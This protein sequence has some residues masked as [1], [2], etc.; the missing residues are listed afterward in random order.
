MAKSSKDELELSLGFDATT[1]RINFS[2]KLSDITKK[3]TGLVRYVERKILWPSRVRNN[4]VRDAKNGEPPSDASAPTGFE[5]EIMAQRDT[6]VGIVGANLS[7]AYGAARDW[8][9]RWTPRRISVTANRDEISAFIS[10]KLNYAQAT[11][12]ERVEEY[13]VAKERLDRFKDEHGLDRNPTAHEKWI[14]GVAPLFALGV[15]EVILNA[16]LLGSVSQGGFF[17]GAFFAFIFSF[18][19]VVWALLI[20]LVGLRYAF[21]GKGMQ[22]YAAI[23][24]TLLGISVA[25]LINWFIAHYREAAEMA[26]ANAN[27]TG[28]QLQVLESV[29][30]SEVIAR[31][32]SPLHLQS[33]EPLFLLI[34]GL[35]IS[36]FAMY[37]GAWRLVDRVPGFATRWREF[38]SAARQR[39]D[40]YRIMNRAI[41]S[42][43]DAASVQ[44]GLAQAFHNTVEAEMRRAKNWIMSVGEQASQLQS[45][46]DGW[47]TTWI[48]KYRR[49]NGD[50]RR[51]LSRKAQ[52]KDTVKDP[53]Q[54]PDYFQQKIIFANEMPS[55]EATM[56]M[57]DDAID[58]LN[59]NIEALEELRSWIAQRKEKLKDEIN[60]KVV[61]DEFHFLD[62]DRLIPVLRASFREKTS[63]EHVRHAPAPAIAAERTEGEAFA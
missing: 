54:P 61:N 44:V 45:Y 55:N 13:K 20:G 38:R 40:A 25:F 30:V 4:A 42:V 47:A 60:S 46:L 6:D 39:N 35:S 56:S 16:S 7:R 8:I 58:D 27:T 26:L 34:L 43:L 36:V 49:I 32:G 21:F 50:R 9:S 18:F 31:L 19:N 17:G 57:V 11:L 5:T 22:K 59:Y 10:D 33:I 63:F 14:A 48:G 62:E 2:I 52:R 29:P 51:S 28:G 53:G 12:K 24:F 3:V 1:G 15:L 41:V 37:E 23:A